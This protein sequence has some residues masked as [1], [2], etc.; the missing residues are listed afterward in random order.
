MSIDTLLLIGSLLILLSLMIARLTDNLGI[1]TLLLFLGVGML[2]GSE[3]P[4]GIAFDDAGLARSIGTVALVF[5]LFSGGLSTRWAHVRE[6]AWQALS[7]ATLGVL[8]TAV[9]VGWFVMLLL[10]VS[11]LEG[12][13]VGA[14][15][16]STDAPA[17]FSILQSKHISL[18]GRLKPL[19]E[20]ESGSNDPM[21]IF[22]TLGLVDILSGTG[23]D[24]WDLVPRFFY[25]MGF[26]AAIGFLGGRALAMLLNR[27]NF[28]YD[29][30]YPVFALAF[31]SFIYGL[32]V[33]VD[34][35]GFLAVYIAGLVVGNS[36]I[37]QK[38]SLFR[39]FD[40]LAWLSQIGMFVT[41]GLLVYPSQ[42]AF[43][44]GTGMAVSFFLILAARPVS[45]FISLAGSS[46][47]WREKTLVSW[48]GIRG[49]VPII[50]A[51]FPLLAGVPNASALFNVVF[52]IVLTSALFQGWSIPVVA[53]WLGVDAPLER[54]TA[55]PLEFE[56]PKGADTDLV[57]FIVPYK[58]IHTGRPI[59]ELGMPDD[60]LITL[61]IRNDKFLVP[62]GGT[63]L[64][65]GDT[66]MVL[67]NKGNVKQVSE[68]L[69][70]VE[71]VES[72]HTH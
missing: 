28:T 19:I 48:V 38:R 72:T 12:L 46:L 36:D 31:A 20:L 11:F 55:S 64:E 23:S 68:I 24:I 69:S 30:F 26:G 3:G 50:L 14:V 34:G 33:L 57:D 52:F 41:L 62:S 13:L 22:L 10:Q 66:V 59:V 17:V 25:Q 29:G 65:P 56:A 39:F 42:V 60:S 8:L 71:T 67:V 32:T 4:G 27:L 49:A 35:S 70:Q 53:R 21:A 5:I 7:L 58:S 37:I 45:V 51:T 47:T 2:A 40:G 16:S 54:R 61:I 15:V 63:T 44:L 43:V 6:T 9:A 1:P 18:K